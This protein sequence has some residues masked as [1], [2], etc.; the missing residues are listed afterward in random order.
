M[1][2]T[3]RGQMVKVFF[4]PSLLFP[5]VPSLFSLLLPREVATRSYFGTLL[6]KFCSMPV[7]RNIS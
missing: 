3:L 5:S 2:V 7:L 4:L 6:S 1:L